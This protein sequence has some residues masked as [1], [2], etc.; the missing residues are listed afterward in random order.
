MVVLVAGQAIRTFGLPFFADATAASVAT[1]F[2][3][4]LLDT[5]YPMAL[6][7]TSRPVQL[8]AGRRLG[9]KSSE[10][11]QRQS[12]PFRSVGSFDALCRQG[13]LLWEI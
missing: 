11:A 3:K 10:V 6:R 13:M 5:A 4:T 12:G 9:D 2:R 8:D 7:Q 1:R